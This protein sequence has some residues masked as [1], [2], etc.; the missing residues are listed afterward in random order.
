[1]V[2]LSALRNGRLSVR[3]WVDP[4]AIMWPE[5]WCHWKIPIEPATFRLVA[6]CLIRLRH[7]AL[8]YITYIILNANFLNNAFVLLCVFV[9]FICI[10]CI[11]VYLLYLMCICC[12]LCVFVVTYVYLLNSYV[13]LLYLCVFVVLCVY[14]CSYF[15]C[16]TAVSI[17]KVLRPA[18]S[19]HVFLGFPLS[20][21]ECWDG[22]PVSKLLLH[23]SHVALPT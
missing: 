13:Y 15:R 7:R 23:A 8:H 10:C 17:R 5:G 12:I 14:C 4:K 19:T 16:R 1:M 22:S 3:G 6:Q 20:T 11:Y 9:V 21:S 2:M 18:T